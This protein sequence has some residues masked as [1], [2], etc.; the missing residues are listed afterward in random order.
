MHE[1]ARHKENSCLCREGARS[2]WRKSE[3]SGRE[4]SRTGICDGRRS[5]RHRFVGAFFTD[6]HQLL[7]QVGGWLRAAV[8]LRL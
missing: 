6:L 4:D 2:G 5:L 7:V 8:A 1:A 3:T